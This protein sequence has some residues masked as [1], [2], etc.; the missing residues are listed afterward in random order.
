MCVCVCVCVC[1]SS[2]RQ[3]SEGPGFNPWSSHTKDFKMVLDAALPNTQHYKVNIKCKVEQ[4]REG[5][6]PSPRPLCCSN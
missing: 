1:K 3:W 4:S 2:V 6:A 5:V